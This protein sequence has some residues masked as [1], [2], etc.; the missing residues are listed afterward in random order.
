MSV[1][2]D[3]FKLASTSVVKEQKTA[4][5]Y[6]TVEA[7]K[8]FDRYRSAFYD[9]TGLS[10][11]EQQELVDNYDE[12]NDYYRM[13]N[14]KPPY[15]EEG[16]KLEK[17]ISGVDNSKY[18]HEMNE[19]E[20]N[21]LVITGELENVIADNPERTYLKYLTVDIPYMVSRPA[22][23]FSLLAVDESKYDIND[24]VV[25]IYK[26]FFTK[27]REY[28]MKTIYN[29]YYHQQYDYYEEMMICYLILSTVVSTINEVNK[30]NVDI[31]MLDEDEINKLFK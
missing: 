2:K 22:P 13:L 17:D 26:E 1:I 3:I 27:N 4:D 11:S 8:S 5:K 28:F 7:R 21:L 6:E 9:Q 25:N 29:E 10:D 19:F 20:I 23:Q 16:V 14:G 24:R 31:N 30:E 12:L 15:G 18:L